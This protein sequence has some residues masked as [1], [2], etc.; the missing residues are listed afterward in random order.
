MNWSIGRRASQP[1][2]NAFFRPGRFSSTDMQQQPQA[3]MSSP[4]A[5][6]P[7]SVYDA[8]AP[9]RSENAQ[10][11]SSTPIQEDRPMQTQAVGGPPLPD[12][13]NRPN[14]NAAR[15]PVVANPGDTVTPAP[16]NPNIPRPGMKQPSLAEQMQQKAMSNQLT[17][18]DVLMARQ[19]GEDGL[20]VAIMQALAGNGWNYTPYGNRTPVDQAPIAPGANANNI[21]DRPG[22]GPGMGAGALEATMQQKAQAGT[23]TAEDALIAEQSGNPQLANWIRNQVAGLGTPGNYQSGGPAAPP[24]PVENRRYTTRI[25]GASKGIYTG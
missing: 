21:Y 15:Q 5:G 7:M 25:P 20:A 1:A 2:S 16:P 10:L 9:R 12:N 23:L 11:S 8:P 4:S 14:G 17:I 3:P 6:V 19:A 24:P 13:P 22:A 18:Q